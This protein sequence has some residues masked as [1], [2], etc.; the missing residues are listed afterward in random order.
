MNKWGLIGRQAKSVGGRKQ[1]E[2]TR[3][4]VGVNLEENVAFRGWRQKGAI[5]D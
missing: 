3:R 5:E 4:A 1:S 2:K